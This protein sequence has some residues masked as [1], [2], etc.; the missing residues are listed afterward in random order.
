MQHVVDHVLRQVGNQ[1]GDF[2]GVELFRGGD[3]LMR[4]HVLD[5]RLA[6]RIRDFEQDFAI[7]FGL[8]QIPD[9]QTLFERQCFKNVGDVGRVELVEFPLQLGKVLFVDKR[10]HQFVARHV[11]LVNHAFHD[12]VL[13]QQGPHLLEGLLH[14]L[15]SLLFRRGPGHCSVPIKDRQRILHLC[16]RAMTRRQKS[17]RG[18]DAKPR[19]KHATRC[20]LFDTAPTAWPACGS[21]PRKRTAGL[22]RAWPRCCGNG[23]QRPNPGL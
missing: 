18:L 3:Q 12:P 14:A 5:E 7:A 9:N 20:A 21:P 6:Y 10:F 19:F 2:I 11:L 17:K 22:C 13:L 15:G 23:F 16:N 1:V 8:D 4:I